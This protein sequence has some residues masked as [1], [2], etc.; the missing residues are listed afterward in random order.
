MP[1]VKRIAEGAKLADK[2]LDAGRTVDNAVDAGKTTESMLNKQTNHISPL[3]EKPGAIGR[4]Q[5]PL[6]SG[7]KMQERIDYNRGKPEINYDLVRP[8]NRVIRGSEGGRV[9]NFW[10]NTGHRIKITFD[11]A[12]KKI[13]RRNQ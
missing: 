6:E 5:Y 3:T 10:K 12:K 4:Q 7:Y 9:W 8:N 2:G 1:N 13:T 11:N